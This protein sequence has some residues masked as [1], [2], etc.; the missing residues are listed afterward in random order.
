MAM[1]VIHVKN[2]LLGGSLFSGKVR[3]KLKNE[4]YGASV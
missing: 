2:K 4:K 3:A 1:T